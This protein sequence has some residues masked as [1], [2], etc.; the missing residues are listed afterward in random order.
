MLCWDNQKIEL[1]G[2]NISEDV[3]QV[4]LGSLLGDGYL[5]LNKNAINAHYREAH[6]LKQENYVLW[7]KNLLIIFDTK[8]HKYST[9]DYIIT[10]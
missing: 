2:F 7:K 5:S 1:D 4:L 8:V 9:I 10:F 6:S 3:K